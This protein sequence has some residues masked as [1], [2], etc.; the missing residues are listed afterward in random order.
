MLRVELLR[1]KLMELERRSVKLGALGCSELA[2]LIAAVEQSHGIRVH[3]L[4]FEPENSTLAGAGKLRALFVD[5]H[6]LEID[7][8]SVGSLLVS[9]LLC[10]VSWD[11]QGP[12]VRLYGPDGAPLPTGL[13]VLACWPV[14]YAVCN[15]KPLLTLAV[16]CIVVLWL[17]KSGGCWNASV[18]ERE[19]ADA[20]YIV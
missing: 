16:L 10:P 4:Q 7:N 6:E 18:S 12:T 1:H 15:W 20:Q 8:Y 9:L 3:M 13:F 19:D 2:A 5:G 17:V 14:Q 11:W